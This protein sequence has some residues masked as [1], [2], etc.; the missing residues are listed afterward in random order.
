MLIEGPGRPF[1]TGVPLTCPP[2][3]PLPPSPRRGWVTGRDRGLVR[4]ADDEKDDPACH[5]GWALEGGE[6]KGKSAMYPPSGSTVGSVGKARKD[7][8]ALTRA[9]SADWRC[10][11]QSRTLGPVPPSVRPPAHRC[12]TAFVLHTHC[13]SLFPP[14]SLSLSPS[15][16]PSI[17]SKRRVC[18]GWLHMPD[19][20]GGG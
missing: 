4:S 17:H 3:P 10:P 8:T 1:L 6:G 20:D 7:L 16:P 5:R 15:A 12:S 14:P 2:P 18:D 13:L 9:G 11:P 19:M